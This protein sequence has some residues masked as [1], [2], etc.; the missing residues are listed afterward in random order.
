[1]SA[2]KPSDFLLI[3]SRAS[4]KSLSSGSRMS[5]HQRIT[6]KSTFARK[7]D[8]DL[9]VK[10]TGEYMRLPTHLPVKRGF[11]ASLFREHLA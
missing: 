11:K 8:P 4:P 2:R 7:E 5:T 3:Y 1:M 10:Q 6:V 9:K